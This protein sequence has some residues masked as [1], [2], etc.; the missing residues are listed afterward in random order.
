MSKKNVC[1]ECEFEKGWIDGNCCPF[2]H[3]DMC[4]GEDNRKHFKEKKDK[5][6]ER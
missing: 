5:I 2:W 4:N 3:L 6:E 1:S